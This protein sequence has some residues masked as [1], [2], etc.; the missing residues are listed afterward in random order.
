[1]GRLVDRGFERLADVEDR[2]LAVLFY[3]VLLVYTLALV[4]QALGYSE[5][6]RLFPLIVG[7]PLSVMIAAYV[8]LRL[9]EDRVDVHVVGFFDS[10]SPIDEASLVEELPPPERYRRE[11]TMVLWVLALVLLTWLVG[12]L[13]AVVAFVLAF[14]YV[15]ER[16]LP[17]AIL[18]AGLVFT[19][20]YLL[21]VQVLGATLW[22]GIIPLGGVFT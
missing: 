9:L 5:A 1:M 17:R 15:Y 2:Y 13:V 21:F 16:S 8:V 14:V 19:F 22:R 4:T 3:S 18:V 12:N 6:A 20:I 11:F 7:V 10:V